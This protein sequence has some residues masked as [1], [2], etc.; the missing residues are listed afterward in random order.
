M[1]PSEKEG[2]GSRTPL[3]DYVRD[4]LART[5]ISKN[6][7]VQAC[8]D[9]EDRSRVIYIQ[10][11]DALLAGRGPTPELWRLRALAA[12]MRA[13]VEELKRLTAEQWLEYAVEETK[14]GDEAVLVA[15]PAGLSEE[16][17]RRIKR[18]AEAMAREE[19]AIDT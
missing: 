16:Q 14:V 17:R 5:M 18:M 15:V 6:Q 4:Y 1:P 7:F 11:L 19:A 10:W 8:I 12:G 13:E 2:Q 3:S 9:P